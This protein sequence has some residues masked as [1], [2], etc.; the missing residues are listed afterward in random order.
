MCRV[1]LELYN[2]RRYKHTWG[3]EKIKPWL[4]D[5]QTAEIYIFS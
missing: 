2:T 1:V 3:F 5:G 4:R